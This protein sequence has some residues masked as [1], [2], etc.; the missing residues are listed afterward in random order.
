MFHHSVSSIDWC[1]NFSLTGNWTISCRENRPWLPCSWRWSSVQKSPWTRY[2]PWKLPMV[3]LPYWQ[4]FTFYPYT[5]CGP[6]SI[7]RKLVHLYKSD[8][9][10]KHHPYLI[11]MKVWTEIPY[12][13]VYRFTAILHT[14]PHTAVNKLCCY[15]GIWL[16]SFAWSCTRFP[17]V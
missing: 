8:I 16:Q 15:I 12:Y 11:P 10:S 5:P 17:S 9:A 7:I 4:C 2:P 6:V 1:K 14:L 13:T 3:Q